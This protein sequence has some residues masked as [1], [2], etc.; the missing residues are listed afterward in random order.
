MNTLDAGVY[1]LL[2]ADT[3]SG[4]VANIVGT[5]GD[6]VKQ[7]Y[8]GKASQ[9]ASPPYVIFWQPNDFPQYAFGNTVQSDHVFY[10]VQGFAADTPTASGP[11]TAGSLA[12][13]LRVL[14]LNPTLTVT[15]KTVLSCR[16]LQTLNPSEDWDDTNG[17]WV[18]SRGWIVE[19]WVASSTP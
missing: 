5:D 16:P 6:G 7:I 14:F 9:K 1:S 18:Y 12:D 13:R 4:G 19:T 10:A 2:A 8:Q 17:R 11:S 3:A 15:G